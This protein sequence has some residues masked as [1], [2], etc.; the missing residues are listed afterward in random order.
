MARVAVMSQS[1]NR[2]YHILPETFEAIEGVRFS[3]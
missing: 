3:F 2:R 1:Y